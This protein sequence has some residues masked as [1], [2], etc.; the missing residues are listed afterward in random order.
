MK[1]ALK[2]AIKMATVIPYYKIRGSWLVWR[3]FNRRSVTL[4]E[5]EPGETNP[6]QKRLIAD[7]KRDGIAI[8]HIDDLFPGKNLLPI[9]QKFSF[10]RRGKGAVYSKKDFF[11]KLWDPDNSEI[12][13][14]FPIVK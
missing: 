5:K 12:S 10:E 1:H 8:T 2:K 4:F 3:F 13:L 6:L 9:L 11:I 14:D 7:L